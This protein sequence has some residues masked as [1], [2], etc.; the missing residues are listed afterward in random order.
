MSA[1]LKPTDMKQVYT[2][3]AKP[4]NTDYCVQVYNKH[5]FNAI[6]TSHLSPH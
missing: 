6:R 3:S 2:L 4:E 5:M 1:L